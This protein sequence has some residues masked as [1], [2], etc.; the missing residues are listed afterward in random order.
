MPGVTNTDVCPKCGEE[1]WYGLDCKTFEYTALS[2]CKCDRLQRYA[3]EFLK[4]KG[5]FEEFQKYV[6]NMEKERA[7]IVIQ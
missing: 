5:L 2:E 1:F 3:E 4:E 7:E 6:E